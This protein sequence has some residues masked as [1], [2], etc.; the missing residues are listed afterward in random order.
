MRESTT[1]ALF[2]LIAVTCLGLAW[3]AKPEAVATNADLEG[4]L[5][6]QQLFKDFEDI[7]SPATL[8]IVKYDE[9]LGQLKRFEIAKDKNTGAWKIPS[10]DDYPADAAEQI[11]DTTAPLMTLRILSVASFERGDQSYYGVVNPDDENL[12][13]GESGVGM[14]VRVKDRADKVLASLIVG[15]E[16][17]DAES[18]YYV[19]V[20]TEDATYVV[21][22]NPEPFTTEF[23]KWIKGDLLDV[24]SID[25]DSISLRDYAILP[26]QSGQ[27]GLSRNFDADMSFNSDDSKWSLERLVSY[28]TGSATTVELG[29]NEELQ[30][31]KLNDLKTAMQDLKI[32]NVHR[33][34]QGLAADLKAEKSLMENQESLRSLHEQ[35][36]FPQEDPETGNVEV[37]AS[38][39][40][41]L[42]ATDKGVKYLLRFGE[43]VASLSDADKE[44]S[45]GLRRFLLVTTQLDESKFPPP[46]LQPLPETI[47]DMLKLEAAEAG[48]S[49]VPE[50]SGS[51]VEAPAESSLSEAQAAEPAITEAPSNE[52]GGNAD[53]T[54]EVPPAENSTGD[55]PADATDP[56]ANTPAEQPE[57][58]ASSPGAG[59]EPAASSAAP[60][61][62]DNAFEIRTQNVFLISTGIQQDE[63]PVTP[64]DG[65]QAEQPAT[66]NEGNAAATTE[67]PV[68]GQEATQEEL[69]ERLEALRERITRENQQ[70]IDDRKEKIEAARKRVA[71]LNAR[72]ADWYYIVS[73]SV[74]KKF[75]I[76]REELIQA[77]SADGDAAPANGFGGAAG[78]PGFNPGGFQL[79]Q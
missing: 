73:D 63:T 11:R 45:G 5:P 2:F 72:F 9:A 23:E 47:E 15:K 8:Q 44:E 55:Q 20:P 60:S 53:S 33:K 66:E 39:G 34:P 59:D 36:F 51:E 76:S 67:P 21:E 29:E 57:A 25:I 41:T 56:A 32:V 74:Y 58:D 64:A 19:R 27:Y 38:G 77:K 70:K 37:L 16:V 26:T 1:T 68:T 40:E 54:A 52:N 65:A 7:E 71:E 48:I 24:R 14:L 31:T 49:L 10:H 6:G 12:S 61:E 35:G 13:V 3:W 50:D 46:D 22:L 69:Q 43:A 17:E 42:V 4:E 78:L 28:E 75:K 79:P 18:Q 62:G 30:A